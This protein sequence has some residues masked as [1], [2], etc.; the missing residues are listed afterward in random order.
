[1]PRRLVANWTELNQ[2]LL[3][4]GMITPTSVSNQKH[5]QSFLM[6]VRPEKKLRCVDKAGWHGNQ[7]VFP[8]GLVIGKGEENESVY[9]INEIC[10]KGIKQKG[11]LSEWQE[12][13]LPLC[14][15]NSRLLFSIGVA[16]SSIVLKLIGEE[17]GGFNFKGRS[18]IGKTK[19]LKVSTS[20]FGSSDYKRSWKTTVNGLEG[21]CSLYNDSLLPL[22]EFGQSDAKDVGEM[23]YMISQGMGKQRSDRT[24]A[25]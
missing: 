20:V 2:A 11:T 13:V 3:D 19:C 14:L 1:M 15:N 25:A 5:L 23:A 6:S 18:S 8:D 22:D 4:F 9:P 12:H 21:V 16:L 24:G 7:Y 10:P 17:G